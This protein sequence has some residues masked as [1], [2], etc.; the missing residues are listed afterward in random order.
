MKHSNK[1][2][3]VSMVLMCL[4]LQLS[5]S[6]DN[7]TASSNPDNTS[8]QN[9]DNT[10]ALNNFNRISTFPVCAQTD[11]ACNSD[12][13]TAAEIV[14]ASS[15]GNTLIYTNSPG[16]SIGFVD[17]TDPATPTG[18][19]E[20]TM[21]GEPTSVT[22]LGDSALV[23]I[24][25]STDFVN[26]SG[27]LVVVDIA[28]R[29]ITSRRDIGGQ[30]DS[31][32]VSPDGQYVALVL[33]NE[34]NEDFEPTDGTPEQLPAG[35]LVIFSVEGAPG[36][37]PLRR[38]SLIGLADRFPTDPEPEYVDINS[39]N[40]AVVTLQENNHLVLVNLVDGTIQA[41]FSAGTIDLTAIDTQEEDPAVIRLSDS[42]QGVPREPD[43]VTWLSTQYFVTADEGDLDG[44]S[45]SFSVFDTNGTVV[46]D[47]GNTLD[48][49]AVQL[50]HYP[51]ARSGNKGNEPEN[52]E[53]ATYAD[54]P[55]LFI[56]SERSS[57]IFVYDATDPAS[58]V[59]IQ[60][61]PAAAGPEGILAIPQRN[62]FIAA[63]EVD[64]RGD[65]LRSALNIYALQS[66]TPA[67]YPT[68]ESAMVD[69]LP[70]AWGALS[71]L[72][73]GDAN[74]LY[75]IDD[76]FY[77]SNRIFT[78]NTS[79][80]PAVITAAKKITDTNGVL[81]ALTVAPLSDL[82]VADDDAARNAVFDQADL[83]ALVNSDGTVNLDP[84]GI[85]SASD[86]GF[87][88]VSEGS[89]TIGDDAR[90]INSLNMLLKL[91]ANANIETAV[92]LP[93]DVNALQVRFG[94]E[95]VAEY[96][97]K[98]YVIMQ[99]AW[100]EENP[101]IGI[102]DPDTSLWQFVYYPLDAVTSQNGGWVGLSDIT[103]RGDGTFL[104]L[105]RDNQGGPDAAIKRLYS[106]DLNNVSDFQTMTKTLVIDLVS[107][108]KSTNALT[109]EKIEGLALSDENTVLIVN[110]N[111]GVEDNSGETQL[112]SITLPL[113]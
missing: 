23:A 112:F 21:N 105:E 59:H 41:D 8:L 93:D 43:G 95:G 19:G 86:N 5:C 63:S 16:A 25:T 87:W 89:G 32:A 44:G 60:T 76:S 75:A 15:D 67:Q 78:I 66:N 80:K 58:P 39:D 27:E 85:A 6:S 18:L 108:L 69:N 53:F 35:E 9:S 22:V 74:T 12:D 48:H 20:V 33:E 61:L 26:V 57:L 31:I 30:P 97:G 71:G 49:L 11:P 3:A 79:P 46:F 77:G 2:T 110:D 24:N 10:A 1:V 88:I 56:A 100:N 90:P 73:A 70:I 82:T 37:W 104:I 42:Q 38:V 7:D 14:A 13:E 4:I 34:R 111:D 29:T 99:R 102:Y 96:D 64:N 55:Y 36:G 62:L 28:S 50:G 103:A 94:F 81:A 84:E 92:T 40:I 47:S 107:T 83:N 51:D 98:A 72:S 91:D 54:L 109:Y 113:P 106:V 45:R 52:A 65:K 101:R 17:I 68:I